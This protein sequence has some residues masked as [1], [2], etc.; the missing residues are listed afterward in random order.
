LHNRVKIGYVKDLFK[1]KDIG[2]KSTSC[3]QVTI[4]TCDGDISKGKLISERRVTSLTGTLL[5]IEKT[6]Q[7]PKCHKLN[8]IRVDAEGNLS[9][10]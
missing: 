4:L 2:V 6:I 10:G 3:Y 9:G 5:Y 1:K 7:C 8:V